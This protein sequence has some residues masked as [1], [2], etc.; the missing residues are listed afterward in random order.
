MAE[1]KYSPFALL[2]ILIRNTDE[3]HILTAKQLQ[4]QLLQLYDLDLERRTIYS[5]IDILEQYGYQISR[6]EDNGKGYYL[7]KRQF[8]PSEIL[9]LCNAIHA[10]H[11]ISSKQS[12]ALITKLLET[13]SKYQSK[14]YKDSV[15]LPNTQ[16]TNN[17]ALLETISCVSKAIQERKMISFTYLQYNRQKEL[18]PRREKP[19]I[20]EPRY[21]VYSDEKPYMIVTS[22]NHK[23][24]IHYRLDK[25]NNTKIL[26]EPSTPLPKEL[27]AYEYA[28]NKLFMFAGEMEPV[29]FRCQ[30]R[31]MDHMI[32]L[33]GTDI[34]VIPGKDNTFAIRIQTSRTGAKYL[35][36][37]Y[38]DSLEIVEPSDLRKEF[39][40]ELKEHMKKY[41]D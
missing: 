29:T 16:K 18:V 32:D 10:S 22:L 40:Q 39:T 25:I 11:F 13:Q 23:G 14:Q 3:E 8:E 37:L 31:I 9:L 26:E 15:Y 27:D 41:K 5:N 21:L 33:F 35:A 36:Q 34:I 30:E 12:D 38:L 4:D 1:K 6:Y 28:K 20:V 24:F 17:T 2:D 7:K 19:Y